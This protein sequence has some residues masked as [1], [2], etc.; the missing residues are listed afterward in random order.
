MVSTNRLTPVLSGPTACGKSSLALELAELYGLEIINADSLLVYRGFDIGTAKPT[1]EELTK[2]PHHLVDICEPEQFYSAADFVRD[3]N[4]QLEKIYTQGKRALIVGGTQFYLKALLFGL[5]DAPTTNPDF[6]K[7]LEPV[8]NATLFEQLSRQ[9]REHALKIGPN[10]RY[11]LIRALEILEFSGVKPSTLEKQARERKP[12]P[13]FQLWIMDRSTQE[14]EE[15]IQQRTTAM[16]GA[17]LIAETQK[18]R[19]KHPHA[20]PLSSVGYAQVIDFLDGKAPAGRLLKPGLAG[21]HDEICLATRQLVKS[22]R[23]FLKA[24]GKSCAAEGFLFDQDR[25]KLWSLAR[26]T[27]DHH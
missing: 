2:I 1:A 14:L 3:V 15:R 16:L 17:G 22:Q 12:D 23:T 7:S 21:L 11:R 5:W 13:R 26:T 18:L 10:D 19:E 25:P 24:L 4:T 6:R 8:D 20:R 27:Y 9:D